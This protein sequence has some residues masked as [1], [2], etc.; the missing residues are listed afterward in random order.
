MQGLNELLP[1]KLYNKVELDTRYVGKTITHSILESKSGVELLKD[2]PVAWLTYCRDA[3][4]NYYRIT[5]PTEK[6]PL[7][8]I[9]APPVIACFVFPQEPME[10]EHG[11]TISKGKDGKLTLAFSKE[12]SDRIAKLKKHK[13]KIVQGRES[14]LPINIP[15]SI[16]CT[17]YV[18]KPESKCYLPGLIESTIDLMVRIGIISKGSTDIVS[19]VNGSKVVFTQESPRTIITIR[20]SIK[21]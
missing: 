2:M 12:Y 20:S 4:N 5:L 1:V 9:V 11:N 16:Q 15:V 21:E 18:S 14:M 13:D 10:K 17:F 8:R 7:K 19:D 3:L 6:T